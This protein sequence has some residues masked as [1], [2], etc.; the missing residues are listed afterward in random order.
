MRTDE[1]DYE[2]PDDLIATDAPAERD[3]G[4]LMVLAR[5]SSGVQHR[6]VRELPALLPASGVVVLND[7]RVLRARLRGK[8]PSG[9]QVEFLLVRSLDAGATRWRAMARASKALRDGATA[10]HRPSSCRP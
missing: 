1:L 5:H 7:T 8:K 6:T 2:L 10:R 9:G 3:G 4:R